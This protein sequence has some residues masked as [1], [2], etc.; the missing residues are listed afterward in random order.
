MCKGLCACPSLCA[1][2]WGLVCLFVCRSA[3][4]RRHSITLHLHLDSD[5]SVAAYRIRTLR[6]ACC[7]VFRRAAFSHKRFGCCAVWCDAFTAAQCAALNASRVRRQ[8]SG[9][10]RAGDLLSEADGREH[11]A[12]GGGHQEGPVPYARRTCRQIGICMS[13]QRDHS[14]CYAPTCASSGASAA[15]SCSVGSTAPQWDARHACVGTRRP[16]LR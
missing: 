6:V 11:R 8:P 15:L 3:D 14:T 2:W 4:L 12:D 7:K 10:G 16:T 9:L 5:R 1:R 13:I